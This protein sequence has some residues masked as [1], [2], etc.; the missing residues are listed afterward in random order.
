MYILCVEVPDGSYTLVSADKDEGAWGDVHYVTVEQDP[1]QS[2][3]GCGT[4][5]ANEGKPQFNHEL[6]CLLLSF[7]IY[8]CYRMC[9]YV[10]E[11]NWN[12][13]CMIPKYLWSSTS[14]LGC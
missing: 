1:D 14:M 6:M 13:S 3:E 5:C 2:P 7:G 11:L 4:A 12:P 10:Q 8:H 9:I